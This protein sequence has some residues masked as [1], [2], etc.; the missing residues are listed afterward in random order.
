M[1]PEEGGNCV[2]GNLKSQL[3]QVYKALQEAI[4]ARTGTKVGRE[5]IKDWLGNLPGPNRQEGANRQ[6][7]ADLPIKNDDFRNT[8]PTSETQG[9]CDDLGSS[10]LGSPGAKEE[11]IEAEPRGAI[12]K[13][14][15]ECLRNS[16]GQR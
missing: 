9:I 7:S 12:G 15:E 14:G 10:H 11:N 2:I 6:E 1:A 4:E 16:D 3:G 13:Q 5:E 8:V